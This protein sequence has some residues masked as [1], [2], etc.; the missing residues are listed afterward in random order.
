LPRLDAREWLDRIRTAF[1][2]AAASVDALGRTVTDPIAA[3]L[4]AAA[5]RRQA[6]AAFAPGSGLKITGPDGKPASAAD[7]KAFL[8]M[9]RREMVTSPSFFRLM[10]TINADQRYPVTVALGRDQAETM[11]DSYDSDTAAKPGLQEVDLADLQRLPVDPPPAFPNAMTQGEALAHSM[12]EAYEGANST[13]S[14]G[15][16]HAVA[17]AAQNQYRDDRGQQGHRLPPPDDSTKTADGRR[18]TYWADEKLVH[19]EEWK[20]TKGNIAAIEHHK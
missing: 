12:A 4:E 9:V 7:E 18:F 10:L 19:W 2:R 3:S 16:A 17:I 20:V 11:I 15:A 13:G 14:Y 5:Q 1:G 8:D 6:A